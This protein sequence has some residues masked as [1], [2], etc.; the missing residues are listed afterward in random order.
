MNERIKELVEQAGFYMTEKNGQ[1][2]YNFAECV[3]NDCIN[4]TVC[5]SITN[6]AGD[7][8]YGYN[9]ALRNTVTAIREQFGIKEHYK[10]HYNERTNT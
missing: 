4:S 1:A 7:Y 9:A 3:I 2:L 5:L 6:R 10:E 8:V